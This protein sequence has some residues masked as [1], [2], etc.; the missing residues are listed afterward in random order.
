MEVINS[1]H[2]FTLTLSDSEL[3][4]QETQVDTQVDVFYFCQVA[5]DN[6]MNWENEEL[7][8][9]ADQVQD[10]LRNRKVYKTVGPGK[11]HPVK[12]PNHYLP[13]LRSHASLV[14]FLLQP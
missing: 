8:T 11:M 12:L 4:P 1:R 9:V 7:P 5:E 6:G 2:A 14:K 13:R 3:W 10:N